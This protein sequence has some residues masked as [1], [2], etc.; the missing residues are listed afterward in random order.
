MPLDYSGSVANPR[1]AD[2]VW[3]TNPPEEPRRGRLGVMVSVLEKGRGLEV[4]A[5]APDSPAER[6][7]I[8]AGDVI[9]SVSGVEA[10]SIEVLQSTIAE[11]RSSHE[12][13][14][15]RGRQQLKLQVAIPGD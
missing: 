14:V 5:V 2:Y 7:G 4:L 15:R 10:R 9:L 1:V 13:V 11:K 12:I 6:A 3:I 8:L